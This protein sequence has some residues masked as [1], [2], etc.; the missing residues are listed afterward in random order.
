MMIMIMMMMM[1]TQQLYVHL[2]SMLSEVTQF[3]TVS[4]ALVSDFVY[5]QVTDLWSISWGKERSK[6]LEMT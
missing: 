1:I 6:T 5:S 4:A 3:I 2:F